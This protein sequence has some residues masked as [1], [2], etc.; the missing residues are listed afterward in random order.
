LNSY[1]NIPLLLLLLL[2][3]PP[4]GDSRASWKVSG[5]TNTCTWASVIQKLMGQKAQ[6][7]QHH[8]GY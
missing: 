6:D 8:I 2:L 1:N 7:M 4:R 5:S 3:I